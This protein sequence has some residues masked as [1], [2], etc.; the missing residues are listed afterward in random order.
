MSGINSRLGTS[1]RSQF[2]ATGVSIQDV[3]KMYIDSR[4]ARL[5]TDVLKG[6]K[7]YNNPLLFVKTPVINCLMIII[8]I[9]DRHQ[10]Q[11]N[12]FIPLVKFLYRI[13]TVKYMN[14]NFL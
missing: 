10:N 2:Y 11:L 14:L 5:G 13:I 4:L 1:F 6:E 3:L 7:K 12:T 8:I 9:Y